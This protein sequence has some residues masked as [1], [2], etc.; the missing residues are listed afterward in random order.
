MIKYKPKIDKVSL[1]VPVPEAELQNEATAV[2]TSMNA[3]GKENGYLWAGG[4]GYKAGARIYLPTTLGFKK[5]TYM[6]VQVG[7]QDGAK[8]FLRLEWNP[9]AVGLKGLAYLQQEFDQFLPDWRQRILDHGRVTRMDIACDFARIRVDDIIV[10]SKKVQ[11]YGMYTNAQGETETLYLGAKESNQVV[12]Y[13]RV[14][15]LRQENQSDFKQ[16]GTVMVMKPVPKYPITRI[17]R[18]QRKVSIPVSNLLEIDNPFSG[19]VVYQPVPHQ[20]PATLYRYPA[21][22]NACQ[23]RGYKRALAMMPPAYRATYEKK[24]LAS[25]APWWDADSVWKHW[26]HALKNAG[27]LAP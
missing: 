17:E 6:R 22:R 8:N 15:K 12:V 26:P 25:L 11:K 20:F 4:S 19:V 10:W 1:T 21:F 9:S 16:A 27:L 24:L 14:A 23:M 18:R 13:D 3:A 2:I 5:G 7:P